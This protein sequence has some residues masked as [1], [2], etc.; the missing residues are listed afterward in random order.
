M[1][2]FRFNLLSVSALTTNSLLMVNFS[3][4]SVLIQDLNKRMI[5]RGDKADG[6]Y[7]LDVSK[8]GLQSTLPNN[9][10]ALVNKVSAHTWHNRLGHLSNQRLDLL[11]H[12]LN[13]SSS[14]C[15]NE[16]CYICPLAKQKRLPF[17][18]SNNLSSCPFDL[19]HCDTWGPF[20]LPSHTGHRYFLTIVDDC[21]RFTWLFLLKH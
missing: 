1:P 7:V 21:T 8:L 18:S 14:L 5:G 2:Q 17:G 4:N 10:H 6:M 15:N 13:C 9:V 16:P 3:S 20:H 11:K 12:Q 19:I